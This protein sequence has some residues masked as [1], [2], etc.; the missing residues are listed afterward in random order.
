MKIFKLVFK[1]L[2]AA[3]LLWALDEATGYP[4]FAIK[5]YLTPARENAT[6]RICQADKLCEV[7]PGELFL[8]EAFSVSQPAV[9]LMG[10][11]SQSQNTVSGNIYVTGQVISLRYHDEDKEWGIRQY[12]LLRAGTQASQGTITNQICC[13]P[14]CRTDTNYVDIGDQKKN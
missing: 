9:V 13:G 8:H 14:S 6:W 3:Y 1:I 7:D 11:C 10:G 5:Y 4:F 12:S 2:L